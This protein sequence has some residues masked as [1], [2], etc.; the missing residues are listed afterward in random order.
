[1]GQTAFITAIGCGRRTT[2]STVHSV[3][4]TASTTLSQA[5]PTNQPGMSPA[6]VATPLD[7][8]RRRG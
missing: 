6:T 3:H 5:S 8:Q 2:S 7:Y 1:M 4:P